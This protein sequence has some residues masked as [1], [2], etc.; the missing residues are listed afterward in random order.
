MILL[1]QRLKYGPTSVEIGPTSRRTH[2]VTIESGSR[3][4]D[5]FNTFVISTNHGGHRTLEPPPQPEPK[6][7]PQ[8]GAYQSVS[9]KVPGR[10]TDIKETVV[11][12][13]WIGC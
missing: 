6:D 2:T 3:D 12:T 8:A 1:N 7:S 13:E 9:F 10:R 11:T 4:R 5:G